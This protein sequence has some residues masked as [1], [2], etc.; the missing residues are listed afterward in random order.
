MGSGHGLGK[1]STESDFEA[2]L[3]LEKFRASTAI[4]ENQSSD[5]NPHIR[6][7]PAASDSGSGVAV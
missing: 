7:P 2:A 5:P 3:G 6:H 1:V 4:E